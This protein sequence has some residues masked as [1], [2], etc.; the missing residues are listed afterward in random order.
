MKE[1]KNNL[2][3]TWIAKRDFPWIVKN[4]LDYS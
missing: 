2:H 3:Y 4:D 1:Q